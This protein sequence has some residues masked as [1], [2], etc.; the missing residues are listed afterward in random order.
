MR[1]PLTTILAVV[2]VTSALWFSDPGPA[3]RAQ[4]LY[5]DPRP[6]N[7][8]PVSRTMN[9]TT[10]TALPID[11]EWQLINTAPLDRIV[12]LYRPTATKPAIQVAPGMH[13]ANQYAK[14]PSPTGKFGCASGTA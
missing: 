7:T 10:A 12:L 8:N 11:N 2:S 14:N 9:N 13:E 5:L 4:H 6:L 1:H 3:V